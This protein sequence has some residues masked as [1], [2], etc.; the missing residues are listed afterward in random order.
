MV[1]AAGIE[2]TSL[3]EHALQLVPFGRLVRTVDPPA[4]V[5]KH[6]CHGRVAELPG[7]PHRISAGHQVQRGERM[8]RLVG[9]AVADPERL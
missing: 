5:L 1:E 9:L 2:P 3:L 4:I 8:P 7:N 6:H